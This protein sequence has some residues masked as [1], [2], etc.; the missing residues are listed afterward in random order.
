GETRVRG[1]GGCR[2]C[3]ACASAVSSTETILSGAS[4][5]EGRKGR[6]RGALP[7]RDVQ[8]VALPAELRDALDRLLTGVEPGALARARTVLSARYRVA[9]RGPG[10]GPVATT[11][12]EA[13]AY[14]AARMPATY[15]AAAAA[16]R[17]VGDRVPDW[18]PQRMLDL[19]SGS[20]AALWAAVEYWPS[21][22]EAVAIDASLE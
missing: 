18:M 8:S 2:G 3:R 20:G 6:V 9:D 1:A 4:D 5:D 21:L 10:S 7:R 14:A 12:I 16:M 11:S 17:E 13:L 22:R 15:A 19:G